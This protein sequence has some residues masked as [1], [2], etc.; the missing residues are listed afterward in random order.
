L[1][2]TKPIDTDAAAPDERE[3]RMIASV[4]I[5]DMGARSALMSTRKD[6]PAGSIAGLRSASV[7]LAA[8]LSGKVLPSVQFGRAALI[9][10]WDDDAAIDRFLAGSRL[11]AKFASGWHLRLAPLRAYG[12]WPGLP[13]DIPSQRQIEHEGPV[14]VLTLGR[15]R[16]S[17]LIRFLRTS[18]MAAASAVKS[19]GLIWGTGVARPLSFVAT[20]SLWD[21]TRAAS[22]FAYGHS[23]PGHPDAIATDQAKPFHHESAF[24]RFHPYAAHGSLGGKNP[25]AAGLVPVT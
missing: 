2:G 17:Q 19:P 15:P 23:D 25:L 14:A 6:P 5:A 20:V 4:H 7:G 11:A 3:A 22:T 12:T 8:P 18:M 16:A 24:I 10:F 13:G 1:R 9:A 21:S